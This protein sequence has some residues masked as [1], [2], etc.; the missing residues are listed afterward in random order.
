MKFKGFFVFISTII[1]LF[2]GIIF[3]GSITQAATVDSSQLP[4]DNNEKSDL[5]IK[6]D[7]NFDDWKD[8]TKHAMTIKGDDDNIKYVSFLTDGKN[9]YLYVLMNPKLSGGYTNFQPDGYTLTVGDK[10]FY[11]SF[12]NHQTV[13]LNLNQKKAVSMNI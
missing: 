10:V 4:V 6:I 2:L 5:G 1:C 11:I 12:N 3:T 8:K 13:T 7:G 9:I